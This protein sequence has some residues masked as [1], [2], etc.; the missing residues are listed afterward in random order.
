MDALVQGFEDSTR[1]RKEGIFLQH[2]HFTLTRVTDGRIMVG[3]DETT[4]FG[5]VIYRCGT[6][7]LVTCYEE[8]NHPGGCYSLVT[9]LGDFL[10]ENGF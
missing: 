1:L 3:R 8:G 6:C 5:C 9:K 4:G 2:D 10:V 7:L